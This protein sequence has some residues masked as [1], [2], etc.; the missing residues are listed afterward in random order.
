[1]VCGGL[2]PRT[3][4]GRLV[5]RL[6]IDGVDMAGRPMHQLAALVGSGFQEPRSQLSTVADT[7][8]EEVAFGPLNL[9]LGRDE[10]QERVEE[11][12]ERLGIGPLAARDPA[13]LSGGQQQL[14]AIGGLLA[15]RPRHL[16]LDE[17]T[18][19][20]DPAGTRL[21]ME[22]ITELA[23]GGASIL[24][25]EQRTDE[26]LAVCQRVVVIEGGRLVAE[27]PAFD[28]LSAPEQRERGIS[29]LSSVRLERQVAEAGL[30]PGL[31]RIAQA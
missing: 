28:I 6:V 20:L 10:V 25:A 5:G 11:A 2:A 4:G 16:V 17:P 8:Y 24:I 19:L 21:V 27:G 26:L 7:V 22:A 23:L 31:V 18:A 29:E 13:S 14:V 15:M 9:G 12:L 3:I 1:M 30:D